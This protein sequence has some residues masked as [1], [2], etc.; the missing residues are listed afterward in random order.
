MRT[1]DD[2]MAGMRAA[3]EPTRLRILALCADGDLTVSELVR[4][5]GQS[6]PRIS[7]HLKVLTAAG[8]LTRIPEGSWVF[9][10]LAQDGPQTDLTARLVDL[11]PLDDEI[12]RRDHERLAQIKRERAEEA[13]DYFRQNAGQ[14]NQVRS[15]HVDDGEVEKAIL[16]MAPA[17]IERHLDLGTGTG[18]VL[19]LLAERTE[20]GQGVDMSREMLSVARANLDAAGLNHC[21]VRQADITQLPF[22][23]ESFDLVTLHQVLHYLADPDSA[24]KAAADMLRPGGMLL[25]VDFAP[26]EE[27]SLRR[28]HQH[29]RLGFADG[30]AETWLKAAGL[31]PRA[32]RHL[33]GD[34]LTVTLWSA[35]KATSATITPKTV[36]AVPPHTGNAAVKTLETPA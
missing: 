11:A 15:L 33:S 5:L 13:S 24:I 4:I 36:G 10:R 34:P 7:R 35:V 18:R 2:T 23:A 28:D 8:L 26:H 21:Q 22:P 9:H 29:R 1:L 32:I 3:A 12:L 19:E 25:I 30:E 14:W 27:E 6:Q 20:L 17:S 31:T 16:D